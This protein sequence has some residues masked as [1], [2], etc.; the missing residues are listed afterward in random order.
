MQCCQ[1]FFKVSTDKR[2]LIYSFL[3]IVETKYLMLIIISNDDCFISLYKRE[4]Q[5]IINSIVFHFLHQD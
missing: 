3:E 4:R 1:N 5:N 2:E